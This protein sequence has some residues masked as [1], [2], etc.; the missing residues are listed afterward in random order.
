MAD[1]DKSILV[2]GATG[3]ISSLVIPQLLAAGARV[4]AFVHNPDKA[5]G[6]A[7]KGVEIISGDF[8]NAAQVQKAFDGVSAVFLL[9]AAG[10][11]ADA[12]ARNAIAAAKKT[13]SPYIVRLSVI[14]AGPDAPT[15]NTRNHGQTEQ[16]LKASGLPYAILRAHFFMQNIFGSAQ[17]IGAEGVFYQGMGDGKLGMI[18]VRDIADAAAKVLLDR[19]H[20]GKTYTLTG[21]ESITWHKAAEAFTAALGQ[22]V[23]YVPIPPEGVAEAIRKMGWGEW[24]A[25]VMKDYSAAYGKGWGDFVTDDVKKLTGHPARTIE[26]FAREVLAPALSRN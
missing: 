8:D 9:T 20:A 3:S 12:Q 13:G 26:Q 1:T 7:D 23:K 16:D 6:L 2:T 10:E 21:P 25:L 19:S 17:T 15:A 4:R 22:P 11:K 24:G 5:K 14:K 18:D